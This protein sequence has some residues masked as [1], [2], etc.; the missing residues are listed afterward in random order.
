VPNPQNWPARLP[1][2]MLEGNQE[3]CVR[4][5][6]KLPLKFLKSSEFVR[7]P[8]WSA[9]PRFSRSRVLIVVAGVSDQN[10]ES[11]KYSPLVHIIGFLHQSRARQRL[12][13][14]SFAQISR[15]RNSKSRLDQR[16]P[17]VIRNENNEN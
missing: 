17:I 11:W 2:R 1:N 15:K 13:H 14:F 7:L 4:L 12:W 9:S 10:I 8:K 6:L 3:I 16:I 5:V